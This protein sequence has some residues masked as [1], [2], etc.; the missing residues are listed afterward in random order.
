M[1]STLEAKTLNYPKPSTDSSRSI[2]GLVIEDDQG[3]RGLRPDL[4]FQDERS[5]GMFLPRENYLL[6]Q[7][8]IGGMNMRCLISSARPAGISRP[9]PKEDIPCVGG[10]VFAPVRDID[11]LDARREIEAYIEN[12][13]FRRV[14]ISE[15]V[16]E[17]QI[18]MDLIEQI[19]N[20]IRRSSGIDSYA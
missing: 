15:L 6:N 11:Y 9:L 16:E 13:G 8:G 19:L 12:V 10:L 5:L 7:S 1:I 14:Y 20:D 4:L 17:L 18:D 3:N 2:Y